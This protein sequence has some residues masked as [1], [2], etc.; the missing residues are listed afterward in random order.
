MGGYQNKAAEIINQ[1]NLSG[2]AKLPLMPLSRNEEHQN[3]R[4]LMPK[5]CEYGPGWV[6]ESL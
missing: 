2:R 5:L 1:E 6:E 4:N 3:P